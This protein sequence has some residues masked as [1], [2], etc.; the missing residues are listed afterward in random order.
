MTVLITCIIILVLI[1]M[2]AFIIVTH[3]KLVRLRNAVKNSFAQVD[4]QLQR[5]FDLVLN[6]VETVKGYAAHE[7]NI[8]SKVETSRE[9][10]MNA[11]SNAEKIAMEKRF[12]ST[13]KS[14]FVV[15]KNYPDLKVN[16]TF[17]NLQEELSETE[18]KI[19][20][21]RQFYN[22]AVTI[23]N[24]NLQMF[25]GNLIAG[26]F[27]FGEEAL[28]NAV[29]DADDAP[30]VDFAERPAICPYCTGVIGNEKICPYCGI[31]V[32]G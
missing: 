12:D 18:D 16:E 7:Q 29:D 14:L 20:F 15:T 4:A 22:D 8:I 19:A 13:L 21:A 10:Y 3:N 27:G 9:G 30:E 5:R 2:I 25:P 11:G 24:T 1:V 31:R 23:Y 26:M 6:L 28:F 32:V 17:L